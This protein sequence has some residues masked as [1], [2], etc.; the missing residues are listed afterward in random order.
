MAIKVSGTTVI[1]DS[2][3][4]VNITNA[5]SGAL[6]GTTDTQ[7]LTNKTISGANNTISVNESMTLAVSDESTAITTGTAK[8]TF[9]APFAMTLYQLP[10]ASLS[11]ASTSGIPTIDINKNGTSIFST[12]LTIDANEK[13]SVTAATAAVL[14]TTTFADDDEITVDI[15]T[16]GTGAKGL[17]ITLYYRRT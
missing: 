2:R 9:R 8:I 3:N 13:T 4:L 17:K 7:T 16:A 11:T 14:S 6:V 1:D 5:P 15:D 10:R 12:V